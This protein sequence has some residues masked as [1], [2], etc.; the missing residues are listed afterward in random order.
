MLELTIPVYVICLGFIAGSWDREYQRRSVKGREN[1]NLGQTSEAS[2]RITYP[3]LK[4]QA[5]RPEDAIA[6]ITLCLQE[7][8]QLSGTLIVSEAGAE[9]KGVEF[10]EK[11]K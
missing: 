10:A 2:L 6:L 4:A 9:Y 1:E 11:G 8:S 5:P 3:S 7:A